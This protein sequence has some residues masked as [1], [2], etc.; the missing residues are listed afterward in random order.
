MDVE[1]DDIGE[2]LTDHLDC[3]L[4]VRSLADDPHRIPELSSDA[5]TEEV[6]VVDDEDGDRL[7]HGPSDSRTSVPVP[8]P[9]LICV[10]PPV[11]SIR[12]TM[13]SRTPRRSSETA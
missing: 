11:R 4:Y 10:S 13:E 6:V 1:E 9:V 3:G 2:S 5:G 7:A 8:G 12:P